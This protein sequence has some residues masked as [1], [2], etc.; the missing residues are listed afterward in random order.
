MRPA[1]ENKA[2]GWWPLATLEGLRLEGSV[3]GFLPFLRTTQYCIEV[4]KYI[5][6]STGFFVLFHILLMVEILHQL[7]GSFSHYFQGFIHPRWCRLSSINIF[8]FL[9]QLSIV[10]LPWS[11]FPHDAV[12]VNPRTESITPKRNYT[13]AFFTCVK[14]CPPT[15]ELIKMWGSLWQAA[16]QPHS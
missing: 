5:H 1:A 7:I 2:L 6:S 14:T 9:D 3:Q 16:S 8:R 15:L 12:A 10:Y 13:H 11:C 4:C